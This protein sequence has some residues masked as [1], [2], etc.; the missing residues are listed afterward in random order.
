MTRPLAIKV[1]VVLLVLLACGLGFHVYRMDHKHAIP[2][3]L[4]LELHFFATLAGVVG[5]LL[6]ARGARLFCILIFGLYFALYLFYLH[7]LLESGFT[8]IALCITSLIALLLA[9]LVIQFMRAPI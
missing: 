2:V 7:A 9:W 1:A 5:I 8:I 3:R 4:C 6:R